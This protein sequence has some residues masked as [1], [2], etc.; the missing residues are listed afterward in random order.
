MLQHVA[1][2]GVIRLSVRLGI[3][4]TRRGEGATFDYENKK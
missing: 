3:I 1:Q 2:L 4:L